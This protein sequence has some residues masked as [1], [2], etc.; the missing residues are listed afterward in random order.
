MRHLSLEKKLGECEK[1][2]KELRKSN[3]LIMPNPEMSQRQSQVDTVSQDK[4]L[5]EEIEVIRLE[6]DQRLLKA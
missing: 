3:C 1:L 6:S 4:A 5:R 2:V